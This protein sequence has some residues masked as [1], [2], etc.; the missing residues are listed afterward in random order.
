M[1]GRRDA[2]TILVGRIEGRNHTENLNVDGRM[3][4]K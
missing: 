2:C 3:I 4:L 1:E